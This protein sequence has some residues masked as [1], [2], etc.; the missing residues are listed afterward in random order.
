MAL[1][2]PSDPAK[3]RTI[4][5]NL[6]KGFLAG[7]VGGLVGTLVKTVAERI[8]PP[9]SEAATPPEVRLADKMKLKIADKHLDADNEWAAE[10]LVHWSFGALVGGVYGAIAETSPNTTSAAGLPFGST[11]WTTT[12]RAM[13]PLLDLAPEPKRRPVEKQLNAF[14]GHLLYGLTVELVRRQVRK[15][16]E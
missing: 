12:Q 1:P 8:A 6:L 13:L 5:S 3:N 11:L 16:M 2:I 4:Q 7:V 10:Q 15:M 9:Q 14:A